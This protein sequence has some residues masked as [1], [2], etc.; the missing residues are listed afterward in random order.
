MLVIILFSETDQDF[1]LTASSPHYYIGFLEVR[2]DRIGYG[3]GCAVVS[4]DIGATITNVTL[5]LPTLRSFQGASVN[6]TCK[7]STYN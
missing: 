6:V 3:V 2:V 5:A 4:T 1:T 7:K